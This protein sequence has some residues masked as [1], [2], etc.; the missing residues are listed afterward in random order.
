MAITSLTPQE[1]QQLL[2]DRGYDLGHYGADGAWGAR[3]S[4]ASEAWFGRGENLVDP[5][6]PRQPGVDVIPP[7]WLPDCHMVRIIGHWTAGSYTVSEEDREHYHFIVGGDL[8]IVRGDN[9]IKSN[10]ATNDADGYAAHT[11][12]CNSGSIGI[13]V[14]CMANAKESPFTPGT[15]P[16]TESQWLMVAAVAADCCRKYSIAVTPTTVLTHGEVQKNLNKPQRGKW[17]INVLPWNPHVSAA[18]ANDLWRR[19]VSARL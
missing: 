7:E 16:M 6:R 4:S 17:D 14:A 13:A 11:L 3:T 2:I 18:Q 15:Y 10:V 5:D 1:Y 9:S 19:E 12:G 8:Q